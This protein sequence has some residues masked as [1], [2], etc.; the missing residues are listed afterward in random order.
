MCLV[1]HREK[2]LKTGNGKKKLEAS[3]GTKRKHGRLRI[4]LIK[5]IEKIGRRKGKTLNKMKIIA[6]DRKLWKK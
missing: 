6:K 1:I 4:R 5:S 2:Q 3:K